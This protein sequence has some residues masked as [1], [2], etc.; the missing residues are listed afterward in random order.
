VKQAIL[1]TL[2]YS[3]IFSFPLKKE[4]IWQYLISSEKKPLKKEFE[5]SLRKLIKEKAVGKKGD[6]FYLKNRASFVKKRKSLE[7]TNQKKL[8]IARRFAQKIKFIPWIKAILI[9]GALAVS[10]AEDEDDIDFLIVTSPKRLWLTRFLLIIIAELSGVRRRPGQKNIKDKICF[11][12]FLSENSL[13]IPVKNQNLFTAHE[14]AQ[15]KVIFEKDGTYEKFLNANLWVRKYLINAFSHQ[16][17]VPSH[18]QNNL[19]FE[20]KKSLNYSITHLPVVALA[21]SGLLNYFEKLA[22]LIQKEYMKPRRTR[23]AVGQSSAFFHPKNRG[24]AI[25]S[26]YTRKIRKMG[27]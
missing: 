13:K 4:E 16:S 10:N 11:N 23:E 27:V 18:Q 1:K 6:F 21:K 2:A 7:K 9:T 25:L 14:I 24:K 15:A 19:K 3:D 20:N 26:N 5:K 17:P 22:F 12:L 8:K